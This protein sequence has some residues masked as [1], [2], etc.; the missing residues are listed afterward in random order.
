MGA[1]I[2]F[3][4][5]VNELSMDKA[6]K[7]NKAKTIIGWREWC[8]L[9]DL[10]LT[11]IA[12]KI[13]TGAKTSSL[14]AFKIKPFMHEGEHWVSFNVHPRQ[15]RR[16]PEIRCKAKVVDERMVTSSNGCAEARIVISTR[17]VIGP[18][19]FVSELTLSNRDEMGF[20]MLIGRQSLA[21]RFVIDPGLAETL[22]VIAVGKPDIKRL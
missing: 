15:R 22:G 18:H 14:H 7:Q 19:S 5:L 13:D 1:H 6:A 21:K 20:R 4:N 11:Q 17:L 16:Q 2:E 10:G 9:P 12:A 3:T 8:S